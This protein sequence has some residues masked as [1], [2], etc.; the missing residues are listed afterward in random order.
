MSNSLIVKIWKLIKKL[1]RR[2]QK[3]CHNYTCFG[4]L[5]SFPPLVLGWVKNPSNVLIQGLVLNALRSCCVW[6]MERISVRLH[7]SG[8]FEFKTVQN[9]L[10][11]PWSEVKWR[12]SFD[13]PALMVKLR[14]K[15]ILASRSSFISW[16][17]LTSCEPN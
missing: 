13:K 2:N 15:L 6:Q 10:L 5:N 1:W 7:Q 17:S 16:L 8:L 12:F 9:K 14:R 11:S 4:K 3:A